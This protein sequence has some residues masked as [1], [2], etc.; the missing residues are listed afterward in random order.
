MQKQ[1]W[2]FVHFSKRATNITNSSLKSYGT[3]DILSAKTNFKSVQNH[4][5]EKT[6]LE[7]GRRQPNVFFS[8]T[9]KTLLQVGS[10]QTQVHRNTKLN[11]LDVRVTVRYCKVTK[12]HCS[13]NKQLVGSVAS[14]LT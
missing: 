11:C 8:T 6:T 10:L 9:E 13:V 14:V 2:Q 12:R 4:F 3:N 7:V 5:C 1:T